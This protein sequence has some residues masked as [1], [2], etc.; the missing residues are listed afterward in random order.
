MEIECSS[1]GAK[2]QYEPGTR[3]LQCEYCGNTIVIDPQ[4]KTVETAQYI[5]PFTLDEDAAITAARA[6]MTTGLTTPDDL[7]TAARITNVKFLYLPAWDCSGQYKANWSASFGYDRQEIERYYNRSA[8]RWETRTRT[9]TDW[10]PHSGITEGTF[11]YFCPA[12]TNFPENCAQTVFQSTTADLVDYDSRYCVGAE[13]LPF[14]LKAAEAFEYAK[15]T[16]AAEVEIAVKNNRMGDH[17]KDWSWNTVFDFETP[18]A[19]YAPVIQVTFDYKA[20]SYTTT[21]DGCD[22]T[23]CLGELPSDKGK[24]E[25]EETAR[26]S[27]SLLMVPTY[28][29]VAAVA[30]QAFFREDYSLANEIIWDGLILAGGYSAFTYYLIK[31]EMKKYAETSAKIR[32]AALI[33]AESADAKI[34]MTDSEMAKLADLS[35]QVITPYKPDVG[36]KKWLFV[37]VIALSILLCSHPWNFAQEGTV[38]ENAAPVQSGAAQTPVAE[39]AIENPPAPIQKPAEESPSQPPVVQGG[40]REITPAN[41]AAV[42]SDVL[43]QKAYAVANVKELL[44]L[45]SSFP[46]P[47][48]GEVQM[49]EQLNNYG[50]DAFNKKD[51]A[52]A[53][54]LFNRAAKANPVNIAIWCNLA[55]ARI[56]VSDHT[57]AQTA[58]VQALIL[59][60]YNKEIWE[61]VRITCAQNGHGTCRQNAESVLK[62]MAPVQ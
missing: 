45:I 6:F 13:V 15:P 33:R 27:R 25:I 24:E 43:N 20:H 9:V 56:Q 16:L 4:D 36:L 31:K 47:E 53:A 26:K 2:L 34:D 14:E 5:K 49:A 62:A 50:V 1:C 55:I 11:R 32:Q 29:A 18:T 17:Q 21:I 51:F 28:A 22:G 39:N 38:A 42:L 48:A 57:G 40:I 10:S 8:K 19:V 59:S 23:R 7:V 3:T 30:L 54:S 46:M 58:A 41:A 60:P 44:D 52:L 61:L 35:Q 37:L 12:G